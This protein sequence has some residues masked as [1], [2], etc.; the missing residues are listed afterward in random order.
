MTPGRAGIAILG[1]GNVALTDDG[2]GVHAVRRLREAHDLPSGVAAVEGATA[3]LL[4]LPLV[5][6]AERVIVVDAIDAGA[7]PGTR[8]RLD[9]GEVLSAFDSVLTPHA[10]GLTDLLRA[11]RLTGAWPLHL[12]ILGLQPA[13]TGIGTEL[14]PA[15]ELGLDGLVHQ[16]AE[17]LASW[18]VSI[19]ARPDTQAAL[20]TGG[21]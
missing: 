11:A 3:G 10:L 1:L 18:G 14:S 9:G 7:P 17:E 2:L 12:V 16:I 8:V 4:L 20:S 21:R 5:A 15:L 6:D 19:R 13:C